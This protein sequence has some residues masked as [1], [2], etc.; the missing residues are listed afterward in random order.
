[1][2]NDFIGLA[3]DAG[4]DSA[5]DSTHDRRYDCEICQDSGLTWNCDR[6]ECGRTPDDGTEFVEDDVD[7]GRGLGDD[8]NERE[9]DF[10]AVSL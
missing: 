10:M 2:A 3:A 4:A 9:P 8:S 1:M 7:F 5:Y 6:C